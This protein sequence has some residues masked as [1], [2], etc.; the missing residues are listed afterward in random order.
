[1]YPV[2]RLLARSTDRVMI[3]PVESKLQAWLHVN[4]TLTYD[5]CSARSAEFPTLPCKPGR[6]LLLADT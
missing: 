5:F 3:L 1:M 2:P 6:L 4:L